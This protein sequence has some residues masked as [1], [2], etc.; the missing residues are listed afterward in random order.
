MHC[1]LFDTCFVAARTMRPGTK[2]NA[3]YPV[4]PARHLEVTDAITENSQRAQDAFSF[5]VGN[6]AKTNSALCLMA[7]D[8][9]VKKHWIDSLNQ[10]RF[11]PVLTF[12]L[13]WHG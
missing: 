2:L 8:E 13:M 3:C 10:V 4:I 9:H 1:F 7:A 6:K 5:Y 12:C 11:F